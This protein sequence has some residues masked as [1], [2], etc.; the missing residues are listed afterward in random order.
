MKAMVLTS[1]Q[2]DLELQH[3]PKPV[4]G[5]G[6]V[7]VRVAGSSVNPI[8]LKIKNGQAPHAAPQLPLVLGVDLAGVVEAVGTAVQHFKPGDEVYGMTGGVGNIPGN[9]A[10]YAVVDAGLIALKPANLSMRDA[11]ALPLVFLSAWGGLVDKAALSKDKTVLVHGGAGGVGH[12]AVQLAKA[13]GARVFA[14]A[15]PADHELIKSYGAIPIDYTRQ[16]VDSYVK[17]YTKD[18]GFDIIFD[19]AGGDVLDAAFQAVKRY[20]GHVVSILGRGNYNLATLSY[21]NATYSGV[22]TLYP[23]VS[24]KGRARYGQILQE[25]TR[26][27]EAGKLV[28]RVDPAYYSLENANEAQAAMAQRTAKGK[29]VISIG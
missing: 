13:F 21:R 23:L 27:A 29:V 12:I 20:T 9:L 24:G 19:T 15:K 26:L 5:R 14:T 17:E 25:A 2:S 8:D 7:L 3:I 1:F 4:P 16:T 28:P 10:E 22:F 6:E 11:A 18:E